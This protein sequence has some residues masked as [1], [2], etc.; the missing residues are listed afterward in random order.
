[1][2]PGRPKEETMR[3]NRDLAAG[4]AWGLLA[5]LLT[6]GWWVMTRHGVTSTADQ[7]EITAMR[8]TISGVLL[9]PVVWRYRRAI[10]AVPAP[11]LAV[12]VL[13]AGA[14]YS[15]MTGTGL[16][17]ASAG[18]GGALVSG[19]LPLFTAL[20][21][22]VVLKE[23]INRTRWIGMAVIMCGIAGLCG[24][25]APANAV[26]PLVCAGL[27]WAGFTVALRRS[28][29]P[30]LAAVALVCSASAILYVPAYLLFASAAP[31]R[32]GLH[33]EALPHA[34]YQG[35]VSAI[36]AVY[37]FG[38]A[39]QLLGAARASLFAALVP[40]LASLIGRVLLAEVPAGDDMLWVVTV[41]LG[42][43]LASGAIR[44]RWPR[45]LPEAGMSCTPA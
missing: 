41:A 40:V 12:M 21:S 11:L 29:L 44:M 24:G 14:P 28:G 17:A 8:F 5:A 16:R 2:P 35:V 36:V 27:M 20:L 9:A 33:I 30:M 3:G 15:L 10:A 23:A 38:R 26:P 32:G 18:N 39:V 6:A 4:V 13:C 37:C 19:T 43:T 22:S 45:R 42:A 7:Y 1:M 34:L 31:A 25:G